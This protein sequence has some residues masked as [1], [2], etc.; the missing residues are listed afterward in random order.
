[1]ELPDLGPYKVAFSRSGRHLLLGGE[2][3]HL[4]VMEWERSRLTC[5]VQVRPAASVLV[6]YSFDG[7][8]GVY[9]AESGEG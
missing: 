9:G 3:G 6:T 5:E 7:L 1:L 2:R 4:A 8:F